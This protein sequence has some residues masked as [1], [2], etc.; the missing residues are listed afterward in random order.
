[1]RGVRALSVRSAHAPSC[2]TRLSSVR[3]THVPGN[4]DLFSVPTVVKS[5]PARNLVASTPIARNTFTAASGSLVKGF[6]F[7]NTYLI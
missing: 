6:I 1:M 4:L 7:N 5:V 2:S 3:A